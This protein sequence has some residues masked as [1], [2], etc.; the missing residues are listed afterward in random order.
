MTC[1]GFAGAM[2]INVCL[3]LR[4]GHILFFSLLWKRTK[5][6]TGR[7]GL[8]HYEAGTEQGVAK[9]CLYAMPGAGYDS[10]MVSNSSKALKGKFD[11]LS[12]HLSIGEYHLPFKPQLG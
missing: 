3:E 4:P 11:H 2:A 8:R 9:T 10:A 1:I 7:R 6:A 5:A 12:L